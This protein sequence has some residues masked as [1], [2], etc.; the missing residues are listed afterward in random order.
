M[1]QVS[2]KGKSTV[3]ISQNKTIYVK[4]VFFGGTNISCNLNGMTKRQIFFFFFLKHH[5]M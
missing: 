5:K 1:A 3:V 2:Y 4:M